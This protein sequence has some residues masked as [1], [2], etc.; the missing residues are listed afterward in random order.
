MKERAVYAALFMRGEA[1]EILKEKIDA[2]IFQDMKQLIFTVLKQ[3][4]KRSKFKELEDKRFLFV[5]KEQRE[6]REYIFLYPGEMLERYQE[7]LGNT[8]EIR[9]ALAFALSASAPFLEPEMFVENQYQN[10][11]KQLERE[12]K[13]DIYLA[14]AMYFLEKSEQKKQLYYE[15]VKNYS[16]TDAAECM[17]ILFLFKGIEEI[18]EI[19]REKVSIIFDRKSEMDIFQ[20]NE[21]YIWFFRAYE[22]QIKGER[23]K[24]FTNLKLLG[25][26]QYIHAKEDSDIFRRLEEIG[27]Q[28]AEILYLNLRMIQAG[29]YDGVETVS[30]ITWERAAEHFCIFFCNQR[31]EFP[32]D[33]YRLCQELIQIHHSYEIKIGGHYGILESMKNQVVVRNIKVYELLYPYKRDQQTN[34]E[35]FFIPLDKAQAE[36]ILLL[37]GKNDF[38]KRVRETLQMLC[39]KQQEVQTYLKIY[40]ELT[41]VDY[42]QQMLEEETYLNDKTFEML[43]ELHLLDPKRMIRELL[44]EGEGKLIEEWEEKRKFDY[45]FSY[46]RKMDTDLK[47]QTAKILLE[48][49]SIEELKKDGMSFFLWECVGI[50]EY[51]WRG[52]YDKMSFVK[53]G[54]SPCQELQLFF[55]VERSI[56]LFCPEKYFEFLLAVL[57][58]EK[59]HIWFPKEHAKK[60]WEKLLELG[61]PN[62]DSKSFRKLYMDQEELEQFYKEQEELEK[63]KRLLELEEETENAYQYFWSLRKE[64]TTEKLFHLIYVYSYR[65]SRVAYKKAFLR[66]LKEYLDQ[67]GWKLPEAA[68][69]NYLKLLIDLGKRSEIN[70]SIIKEFIE[71]TE[72]ENVYDSHGTHRDC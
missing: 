4:N 19:L 18:W 61:V 10:F 43:S 27:Y 9:R 25:K 60:Y 62:A 45:I 29:I 67:I 41:H 65:F 30:Q 15:F 32:E 6:E 52:T 16:Y 44:A 34:Q 21:M 71:K 53:L 47:F 24:L 42:I 66:F 20:N 70:V 48:N 23:K 12:A 72:V 39:L 57:G 13:T 68:F 49:R 51:H 50:Q 55:W 56:Y 22:K 17:G 36:K 58:E 14:G 31:K 69:W 1:M 8:I 54:L 5:D 40:Q 37:I 46:I 63:Q 7:K 26:L 64:N 59:N 2:N 33:I 38:D 11:L 3:N 35:W 28:K